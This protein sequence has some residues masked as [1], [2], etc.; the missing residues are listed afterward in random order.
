[1]VPEGDAPPNV[2]PPAP[3]NAHLPTAG[4][5]PNNLRHGL[6]ACDYLPPNIYIYK[7]DTL[8]SSVQCTASTDPNKHDNHDTFLLGFMLNLKSCD[9]TYNSLQYQTKDPKPAGGG[10]QPRINNKRSKPYDRI[11]LFADLKSTEGRCFQWVFPT[12][13]DSLAFFRT[14]VETQSEGVGNLWHIGEPYHSVGFLGPDENSGSF[15]FE[16]CNGDPF[17]IDNGPFYVPNV[18]IKRSLLPG[19]TA[20]FCYH[21]QTEVTCSYPSIETGFLHRNV[22][23][24]ASQ[25]SPHR[26]QMRVCPS[27]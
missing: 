6:K 10:K 17:P 18:P 1:M 9:S 26:L 16:R 20:Y 4:I 27:G 14:V 23:R 7:D 22:L 25:E 19:Q 13:P 21:G 3:T 8:V 12:Q 5:L 24:P 2:H 15:L 11:V